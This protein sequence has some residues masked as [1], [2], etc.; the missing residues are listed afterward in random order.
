[1][2]HVVNKFLSN[3][4]LKDLSG[5]LAFLSLTEGV[6]VFK[7]AE[8]GKLTPQIMQNIKSDT[9]SYWLEATSGCRTN[10]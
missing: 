4:L 9:E 5:K 7:G 3:N 2:S 10:Y 8:K 1:M 6:M